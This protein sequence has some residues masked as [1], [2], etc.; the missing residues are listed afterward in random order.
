MNAACQGFLAGA[1]RSVDQHGDVGG[2]DALREGEQRERLGVCGGRHFRATDQGTG[3]AVADRGILGGKADPRR[4]ASARR[5][6]F[7]AF[8]A[9]HDGAGRGGDTLAI[10]DEEQIVRAG[11][12]GGERAHA[13]TLRAQRRD[14]RVFPRSD[15]G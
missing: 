8:A 7:A 12:G 14:E 9:D 4:C 3:E 10:R 11:L 15:C 5:G 1:G 2:G 13:E 6:D